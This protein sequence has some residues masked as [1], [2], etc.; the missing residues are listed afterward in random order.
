MGH[1]GETVGAASPQ[2]EPGSGMTGPEHYREAEK[3]RDHAQQQAEQ[4]NWDEAALTLKFAQVHA[5]LALAAGG[6]AGGHGG[7]GGAGGS[8]YVHRGAGAAGGSQ[9]GH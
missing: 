6:F 2:L 4:G 3:Q 8:V 9:P 7:Q 1:T 5:T